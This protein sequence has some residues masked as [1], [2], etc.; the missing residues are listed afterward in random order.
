MAVRHLGLAA[1]AWIVIGL[2]CTLIGVGLAYASQTWHWWSPGNVLAGA[3]CGFGGAM[4]GLLVG[5]LAF[6]WLTREVGQR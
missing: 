3:A 5:A 4:I 6:V 2:A 1:V